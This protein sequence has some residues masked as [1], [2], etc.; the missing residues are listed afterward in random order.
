MLVFNDGHGELINLVTGNVV[1][2]NL[3]FEDDGCLLVR[4]E[5]SKTQSRPLT[6]CQIS[7][8]EQPGASDIQKN[9]DVTKA[10]EQLSRKEMITTTGDITL[11][12]NQ[13]KLETASECDVREPIITDKG[14]CLYNPSVID[15]LLFPTSN[16]NCIFYDFEHG[17]FDQFKVTMDYDHADVVRMRNDRNQTLL[18]I[19]A[20]RLVPYVWLRLLLMRNIDPTAQDNDGYTAAHYAVEWNNVEIL[21]AL[22]V[23]CH[24][25]Q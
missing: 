6:E 17:N 20:I 5:I 8:F 14:L 15:L 22:T 7:N 25:V 3:N 11:S 16:K 19:S 24:S 12:L 23:R 18:H 13:L 9:K 2:P 1:S 21:K 4:S 10:E